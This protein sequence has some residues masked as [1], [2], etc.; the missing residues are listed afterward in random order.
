MNQLIALGKSKHA[1]SASSRQAIP[2]VLHL[3]NGEHF[4][5]AERVQDL[6]GMTLPDI[7]YD[8]GFA[9]LK[10]RLFPEK[11]QS[12]NEL[13]ET[14]M[15]SKLDFK[16]IR[17]ISHE[18]RQ[19]RFEI[20]HAHTP[21]T[22]MAGSLIKRKLGLP[23]IYH[24]HSPV[25]H[26]STRS[27]ANR[28][29]RFVE[30]WSARQVDHFIC[31]SDSIRDYMLS[32]GHPAEKL[33]TVPNGVSVVNGTPERVTPSQVWTLGTTALFRPRKGTEVLL[34][35]LAI[36]RERQYDVRLLAVGPFET[37]DYES[38]IQKL[39]SELGLADAIEW[40]GFVSDV[41]QQFQ[42]M[43][44]FVLPS[45]FGEGLPMVILEAMALGTPVISAEVEGVNQA[46]RG[47]T[48]GLIFRPGDANALA[49]CV[50]DLI[51]KRYDWQ[52]LRQSALDRQ[53]TQFSDVSM[54]HGVA[55]VY[56]NLLSEQRA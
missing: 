55:E 34:Q 12:E 25:G 23:L 52:A 54:A 9:C 27:F 5:G 56:Q 21:R 15:R 33:T 48:D 17:K 38:K 36:L 51:E 53:R 10:P 43:D 46:I 18:A 50:V 1:G 3:I 42:R 22:L 14:P 31:V 29:N 37:P 26:D 13:F 39:V 47:G 2:R 6:L 11:R 7:G 19:G 4:S 35:A 24:V 30:S 28:I 49:D 16:T 40:T 8:V 20:L 41:A 44:A 45:L 32:I